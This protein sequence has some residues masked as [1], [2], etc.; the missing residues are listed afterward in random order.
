MS[1]RPPELKDKF[2]QRLED[3]YRRLNQLLEMPG[4]S[5]EDARDL[6]ATLAAE[7]QALSNRSDGHEA[8]LESERQHYHDLF[9]AA[10]AGY[11][12]T[13]EA[14][15]IQEVNRAAAQLFNLSPED[16]SG[17]PIVMF[18]PEDDRIAFRQHL[19]DV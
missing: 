13:D 1:N 9:E 3:V 11:V 12:I 10:P 15:I 2:S 16:L 14:G 4:A 6:I 18:V 17:R 7:G 19:M 5:L 8:L